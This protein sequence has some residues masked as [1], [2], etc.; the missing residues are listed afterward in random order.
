M[1]HFLTLSLCFLALSL[2][3]QEPDG[4]CC[5]PDDASVNQMLTCFNVGAVTYSQNGCVEDP[6][7][8]NYNPSA[9][10]LSYCEGQLLHRIFHFLA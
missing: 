6:D 8:S 5:D 4:L 1:K 9:E 10:C 2:S 7:C 3:A